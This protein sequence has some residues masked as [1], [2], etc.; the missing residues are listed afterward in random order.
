VKRPAILPAIVIMILSLVIS[1]IAMIILDQPFQFVTSW[2]QT[3]PYAS[4]YYDPNVL[5]FFVE[6]WFFMSLI[7][8]IS[9]SAWLFL[10]AQEDGRESP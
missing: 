7:V 6:G 1:G 9:H 2:E 10:R 4:G 3:G 5:Q 8:L